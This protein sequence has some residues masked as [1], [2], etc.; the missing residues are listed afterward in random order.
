M[1]KII[2]HSGCLSIG[3]QEKMLIEFLK[4][5]APLKYNVL[6][7][8]EENKGSENHYEKLIPNYVNY[9]FLTTEKFMERLNFH[10]KKRNFISKII[11]SFLLKRKKKIA[12]NNLAKELDFSEIIIDYNMGLIRHMDK[13]GLKNKK[14]VG[15]SHAGNGERERKAKKEKNMKKYT[16]IVTINETM[17]KGFIKNYEQVGVSIHKI[18][19]F[20]DLKNINIM[21]EEKM[22]KDLGK[23]I[24][25]VGA[26]TKN[27]NF[28]LLIEAFSMLPETIKKE[29]N[30]VILG[31]GAERENLE[32]LIQEK[33]LG[34][35]IALEGNVLNPYKYIKNS[36]FCV[37]TSIE[38]GFGL[39]LAEAL[40]LGKA[41]IATRN[42][43]SCEVL[44]E[45]KYGVLINNNLEELVINLKKLITDKK[46]RELLE[47]KGKTKSLT[48][49]TKIIKLDI[50]EF[51]DKL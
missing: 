37:S 32:K 38:E 47:E 48:Y 15:W 41:I 50:E 16:H 2:I 10:R 23:Y 12:I 3:G 6:L 17:K 9:K 25:S 49:D 7:L 24:L 33:N 27:K 36:L 34:N 4:V 8:I 31:E 39:V 13:L 35:N 29:Y 42:N 45:G 44:E 28:S 1:K 11:Y 43:G 14:M 51:I 18:T 30:L 26:L 40:G 19:N 46:T 22:E 5:L 20:I 21:A